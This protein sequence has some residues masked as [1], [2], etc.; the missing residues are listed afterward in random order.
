MKSI[1]IFLFKVWLVIFIGLICFLSKSSYSEAQTSWTKYEGN[2]V[3]STGSGF[4]GYHVF[5]PFVMKDGD[6]YKMWYT[7]YRPTSQCDGSRNEI[8]YATSPDGVTWTKY[9][10]NPILHTSSGSSSWAYSRVGEPTVIIDGGI[11]KMWFDGYSCSYNNG[12]QSVGYATSSD[13]VNW[14]MYGGNPVIEAD[15][16]EYGIYGPAV[17]YDG[18]TYKMWYGSLPDS[19]IDIGYAASSDGVNWAKYSGNP[20]LTDGFDPAVLYNGNIYHM[21]YRNSD[22]INYA[23]SSDGITWTKYASNPIMTPTQTWETDH[24]ISPSVILDGTF[25]KMWYSGHRRP[26]IY[27][28]GYAI[29]EKS[30][31]QVER[32]FYISNQSG[33]SDIWSMDVDGGNKINLTANFD[34]RIDSFDITVDGSKI[35]FVA[36]STRPNQ[37]YTMNGD[38]SDISFINEMPVPNAY[39]MMPSWSPD[40]QRIAFTVEW[41]SNDLSIYIIN[42]DGSGLTPFKE[43]FFG[44]LFS[45]SNDGTQLLYDMGW[46]PGAT[47]YYANL[48]NSGETMITVGTYADW[49]PHSSK[50]VFER[51]TDYNL[52]VANI[53]GS[54]VVQLTYDGA[55]AEH[56]AWSY[57]G[58]RILFDRGGASTDLLMINSDGTGLTILGKGA[59]G[60]LVAIGAPS[61]IADAG[62]DQ[63]ENEGLLV[64]LDGSAS[65]NATNYAWSQVGGPTVVL[66][67]ANTATPSFTAPYVWSNQTLTFEL[68]VDDGT[69]FSDPDTVDIVV[70]SV[71]SPP[72]ADA[73]D[74]STIKEGAMVALDGSNSYDPESDPITQYTW[75]QVAGPAVGLDLT[76]PVMPSFM[77]SAVVGT[78]YVFKLEVSDGKESSVPS[79]GTDS[80]FDDTVKVTVVLNSAPT[81]N[82]GLDAV[83]G[84]AANVSLAGSGSDPDG[85][86]VTYQWSQVSGPSVTIS[87]SNSPNANFTAPYVSSGGADLVF[88]LR[89]DDNDSINPLFGTDQVTIHVNNINDPPTC[90]LAQPSTATLWPPNH[91]MKQITIEGV[92]DAD[93]EYNTV[94]LGITGVTQDEPV[95]GLGDGDSSPDAVIQ[96]DTASD[97]VLIRAERSGTG[98]GRV[99]QINFT[100]SD[101]AESCQGAVQVAVPHSRK[102]SAVDDGQ[103]YDSTLP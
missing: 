103:I 96:D 33:E 95:N 55:Y 93:S 56:A 65:T 92:V 1:P 97:T 62:P 78:D 89:V 61:P 70:V 76:N 54:N 42:S 21:W 20:V 7:G 32:V 46:G 44:H 64:T 43:H 60:E 63:T 25:Y 80:S 52:Y 48:D 19:G 75:T 83:V 99:Y 8:G 40:A 38:G 57:D 37:L 90:A 74:D 102:S 41:G 34:S 86:A 4:D 88:E 14:T 85:D 94:T 31:L 11:Y 51:G 59:Y 15:S 84:E 10:E 29:S 101:E 6:T 13:G 73:G 98:N 45:W 16:D 17:I 87:N 12:K 2:P 69:N 77:A 67:G 35:V 36:G 9:S 26:D 47:L 28:I 68:I 39:Q 49:Y 5:F 100:A 18:A 50:V 66:T 22:G 71:N 79:A 24:I 91:K 58:S 30:T 53:D 81:A 82:A 72:V 27:Q 3:L 23:T